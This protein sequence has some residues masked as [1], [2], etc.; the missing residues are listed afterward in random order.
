MSLNQ[1]RIDCFSGIISGKHHKI[2]H[3]L[4]GC[5][6]R[7]SQGEYLELLVTNTDNFRKSEPTS[8]NKLYVTQKANRY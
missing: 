6:P 4:L 5:Q 7:I 2:E 1:Y 3:L 8:N